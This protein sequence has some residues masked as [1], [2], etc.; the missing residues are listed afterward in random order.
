MHIGLFI[1][2]NM[3]VFEPGAGTATRGTAPKNE[4]RKNQ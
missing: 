3:D 4:G 2:F 1:P